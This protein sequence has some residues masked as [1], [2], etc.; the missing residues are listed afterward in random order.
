MEEKKRKKNEARYQP[1][2]AT[3]EICK[4]CMRPWVGPMSCEPGM[5]RGGVTIG[6]EK[7]RVFDCSGK[8]TEISPLTKI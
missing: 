8:I 3:L 1:I 4:K 6:E 2:R 7:L 5:C